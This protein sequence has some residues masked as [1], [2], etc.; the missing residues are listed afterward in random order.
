M[1]KTADK[2]E[3]TLAGKPVEYRVS[4]SHDAKEPR[5]D[6]DIRGIRVIL[7]RD[8]TEEPEELLADNAAWILEKHAKYEQ[9]REQAPE[10]IFEPG[11]TFPYHGE[12]HVLVVESRSKH[13]VTNGTIRLRQSAVSQSSLKRVLENFYRARAREYLTERADHYAAEMDVTYEKLEL[14]NQR[15]RWGSCS[16]TGT[17]SLNWRLMM[18]PPGVIDYVIVHELAHLR[19]A[20]HTRRFWQVVENQ[21]PNYTEKANWLDQNSTQ[22]IFSEEDL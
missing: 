14:R 1:S 9:Y 7:P 22:L 20:N 5:I 8:G 19:E 13:E 3:T 12:T 21:M 15:T 16:T 10:R 4:R 6:I 18:G 2:L 11:E 17:L